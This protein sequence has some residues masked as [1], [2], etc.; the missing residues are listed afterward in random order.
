MLPGQPLPCQGLRPVPYGSAVRTWQESTERGRWR[1]AD[2]GHLLHTSASCQLEDSLHCLL[3]EIPSI[4]TKPNCCAFDFIPKGVKQRLHPAI[5][6]L[7][8]TLN[9]LQ[10]IRSATEQMLES[11]PVSQIILSHKN[12]GLLTK[13]TGACFLTIYGFGRYCL[14]LHPLHMYACSSLAP[15]TPRQQ[16]QIRR[17]WMSRHIPAL[18]LSQP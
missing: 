14:H 5:T 9:S 18:C 17:D 3:V 15:R 6:I 7:L 16:Q 11:L 12:A 2:G 10:F 8:T 1:H 13:S 4:P